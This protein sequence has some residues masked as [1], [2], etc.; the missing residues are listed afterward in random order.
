MQ[1]KFRL[2]RRVL[3]REKEHGGSR[4]DSDLSKE[5]EQEKGGAINRTRKSLKGSARGERDQAKRET[6][7]FAFKKCISC[8]L[9]KMA[10]E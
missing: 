4:S 7:Y 6:F 10:D 1:K 2:R 5:A 9:E 8:W 3:P